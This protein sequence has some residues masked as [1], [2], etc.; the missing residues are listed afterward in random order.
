VLIIAT[1]L[2]PCLQRAEAY[3]HN[4][5]TLLGPFM[6]SDGKQ[7]AAGTYKWPVLEAFKIAEVGILLCIDC[8]MFTCS[9]G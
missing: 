6:P 3:I 8:H 4:L 9:L 5:H 2:C 1:V 7:L